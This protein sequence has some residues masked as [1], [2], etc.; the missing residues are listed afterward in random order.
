MFSF[1]S[2]RY[3]ARFE[4]HYASNRAIKVVLKVEYAMISILSNSVLNLTAELDKVLS[5]PQQKTE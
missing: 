1:V 4:G 2:L 3:L 5:A